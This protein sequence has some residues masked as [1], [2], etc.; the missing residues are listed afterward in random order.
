MSAASG[1][2]RGLLIGLLTLCVAVV[3]GL[4]LVQGGGGGG[5]ATA[6]TPAATPPPATPPPATQTAT[7]PT[8]TTAAP[9]PTGVLPRATDEE[10]EAARTPVSGLSTI[11]EADLP[12]E[13]HDTLD[14]IRARGPFPYRQDDETFFNREGILPDR[15]R[16][17]YREYTVETRGSPD[18]GALRIVVGQGGDLYYTTDHYDSFRQIEEGR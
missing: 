17:Y 5:G 6:S 13:A 10:P 9:D 14:L 11:G 18:R 3:A 16:G 12:S 4:L 15:P 7:P 1:R 2:S 8:A